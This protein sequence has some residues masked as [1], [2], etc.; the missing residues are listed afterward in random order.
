M[1]KEAQLIPVLIRFYCQ[2]ETRVPLEEG[3][4]VKESADKIGLWPS[5]IDILL[6]DGMVGVHP[7][8]GGTP[9]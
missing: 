9:T 2:L 8:G 4:S 1:K 5:L 3:T 7:T 6:D